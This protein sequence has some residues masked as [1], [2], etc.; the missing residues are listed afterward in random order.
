VIL[1]PE[2]ALA[3]SPPMRYNLDTAGRHFSLPFRL[4]SWPTAYRSPNG[5][6]T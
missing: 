4:P 5:F 6:R 1:R 3:A 2:Q